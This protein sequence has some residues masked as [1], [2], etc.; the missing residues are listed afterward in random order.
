MEWEEFFKTAG[1]YYVSG[2][3]AAIAGFIPTTGNLLHH[4]VEMFLKGG[5]SK[6]GLS[7][8]ELKK[9]GHHL[10]NIWAKFKTMFNDPVLNKFDDVISSLHRFEDIRYPDL[11]VEK[12]MLAMINITRQ[13]PTPLNPSGPEPTYEL[14]VQDIDE[15]VGQIFTTAGANPTAFLGVR[16][17]KSEAKQYLSEQNVVSSLTK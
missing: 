15:L 8:L 12:G 3:Y 5:L 10:P 17:H 4:A 16:F 2:R 1:Q 13:Q 7:L 11:I 14:C 6:K 9:L